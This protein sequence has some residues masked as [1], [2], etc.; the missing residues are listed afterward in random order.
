MS[1]QCKQHAAMPSGFY[2]A[3]SSRSSA[4]GWYWCNEGEMAK[5]SF[6]L[7]W[8]LYEASIQ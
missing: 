2:L 1:P 8:H 7:Q 5:A 4:V 6:P 3:A